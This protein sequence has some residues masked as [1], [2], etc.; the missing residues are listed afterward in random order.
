MFIYNNI[1]NPLLAKQ[2]FTTRYRINIDNSC[3]WKVYFL[4]LLQEALLAAHNTKT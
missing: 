4:N 2:L 1:S 3:Q